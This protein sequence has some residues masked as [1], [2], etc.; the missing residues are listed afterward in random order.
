M[1]RAW[2]ERECRWLAERYTFE[3]AGM[4]AE[5]FARE[6]GRAVTPVAIYQKAHK[7][8]LAKAP[9]DLPAS[10]ERSVRWSR[11]PEMQAWMEAHDRGQCATE[12]S[13]Q[14]AGAFGFRLTRAQVSSWRSTNG[15]TTKT[16]HGGRRPA[17][18]GSERKTKGY[19]V[20]KVAESPRVAST[21]DNWR[22]KHV[23]EYERH[24]G[25]VP[26]GCDVVMANRDHDDFSPGNLV[27]VPHRLMARINSPDSPR[28]HD[29]ESL[30]ACVA[31]CELDARVNAAEAA[32]PRVCGVCGREFAP[33]PEAKQYESKRNVKTCPDCLAAGKKSKG[34]TK[35]PARRACA[36]CGREFE[37]R[38]SLQRRCPDCVRELPGWRVA[39]HRKRR[40]GCGK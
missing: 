2:G 26:E 22:L 13:A 31:W 21:K 29:A 17:P 28:W 4:L 15:R 19:Y 3:H 5:E 33:P 25:P 6:F 11:E 30:R 14:F 1:S 10:A 39:D 35:A 9:R 16:S 34:R 37:A 32:L 8:G 24:F 40:E 18:V 12:L 27:A 7:M 20:V 36:V 38:N 23:V